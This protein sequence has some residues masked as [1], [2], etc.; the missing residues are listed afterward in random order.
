MNLFMNKKALAMPIIFGVILCLAVWVASLSWTMTN[1]RA[2][3]Q[4]T[5]TSRKAYFMARSGFEHLLL[6]IK[7]MQRNCLESMIAIEQANSD[8]KKILYPVFLGDIMV[9]LDVR[10]SDEHIGYKVSRFNVEAVDKNTS[11]MT[12][13]AEI[14]GSIGGQKNAISRLMK[15]SR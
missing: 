2:R 5:L 4:Q 3:Y 13:E 11:T 10:A 15:I 12:F 1:S 8:E 7:Y 9:P 14:T 6:K